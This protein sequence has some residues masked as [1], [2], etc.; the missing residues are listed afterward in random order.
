MKQKYSSLLAL[1]FSA[2][3]TALLLTSATFAWFSAN[4]KVN[5]NQVFTRAGSN[6]LEL[7]ISRSNDPFLPERNNELA[8]DPYVDKLLPVSTANLLDFF[9][10]PMT[11]DDYAKSFEKVKDES[12]YY[13]ETVYLQAQ[14]KGLPEGSYVN[15]YLDNTEIPI[16]ETV[17]G[18]LLTA[19][20]LGLVFDSEPVILKL[21][22][23][24]K[25]SSNTMVGGTPIGSN[26]VLSYANGST[27]IIAVKDP[28]I[29]L[30]DVQLTKKGEAGKVSLGKMKLDEI[31]R[32]DIYF[33]LEGC[34]PDCISETV[35]MDSAA[36]NLAFYGLPVSQEAGA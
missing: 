25:G 29:P 12:M 16:V 11:V 3:L 10:N 17:D 6:M 36:L 26:K 34:D 1:C 33:Y 27:E 28:A 2:V 32:L 22:N 30:E 5:T 18:E 9:Y 4:R 35:A 24:D 19:A 20:R 21:S 31:Y 14:N 15:L 8:L 13:H 23:V 7:K